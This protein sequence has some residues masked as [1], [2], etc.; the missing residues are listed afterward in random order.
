MGT[1]DEIMD[2]WNKIQGGTIVC[3]G[4]K[5][6][7]W[8][9]VINIAGRY[10]TVLPCIGLHPW[11]VNTVSDQWASTLEH[12]LDQCGNIGCI[13][14]IGL[15]F[16]IKGVN[17]SHQ[18][19]IFKTQMAMARERKIPVSIHVRKGWGS[20]IGILKQMGPLPE[21]GVIHS[22]SG[23]ADMVELFEKYGL[24]ISFSGSV[25]NPHN[26]KVRNALTAV[27][28]ERL[29]IETDSPAILPR[30][31]QFMKNSDSAWDFGDLEHGQPPKKTG[32]KNLIHSEK[33]HFYGSRFVPHRW[34]E[35][36][37][38]LYLQ[39]WNEPAN[40]FMVAFAVSEILQ[41]EL[42]H[43]ISLTAENG[44]TLFRHFLGR[45]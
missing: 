20:F 18:E 2:R 22:Y 31:P 29:L 34:S 23:S 15:D 10:D 42:P 21:G 39:G 43:V 33:Q 8:Q 17:P 7:D 41:M 12:Y 36:S 26:K 30:Y 37:S 11:F 13:G 25:T 24:Y 9:R 5:E 40:I 45:Y 44:R 6:D 1:L 4:T 28:P 27:S 38:P 14:E 3:C 35:S 16:I 32:K 19:K